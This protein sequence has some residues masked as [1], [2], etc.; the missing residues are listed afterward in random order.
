[1]FRQGGPDVVLRDLFMP[2]VDGLE[3]IRQ[4]R[5]EVPGARVVAM[6]GGK[7][8][9]PPLA[10]QVPACP[11][12]PAPP[13]AG[14]FLLRRDLRF[15]QSLYKLLEPALLFFKHVAIRTIVGLMDLMRQLREASFQDLDEECSFV[16]VEGE[17]VHSSFP[18]LRT[19]AAVV[20][21]A[22]TLNRSAVPG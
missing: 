8:D 19:E 4:L 3:V 22:P 7:G 10:L 18:Y 9:P 5:D 1:V 17:G 2:E 15:L 12:R 11:C 14:G 13:A 6:S 16:V 21:V 20:T